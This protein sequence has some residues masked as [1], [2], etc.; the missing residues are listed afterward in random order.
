MS[1][2]CPRH[3]EVFYSLTTG[4]PIQLWCDC[5]IGQTHTYEQWVDRFQRPEYLP[6]QPVPAEHR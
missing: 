4:E 1:G 6:H 3:V 5:P 2:T